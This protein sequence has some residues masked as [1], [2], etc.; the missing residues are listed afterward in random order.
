MRVVVVLPAPLGPRKP[1]TSPV[2][3]SR[4]RPSR[5][6]VGPKVFTSP[7]V[8]I[9]VDIWC[10][11]ASLPR[12]WSWCLR[13]WRLPHGVWTVRGHCR[14]GRGGRGH[15]LVGCRGGFYSYRDIFFVCQRGT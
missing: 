7:E 4:S 11:T 1:C 12:P 2:R 6:L 10:F 9:A 14:A 15:P 8:E 5:A 13:P 3:T